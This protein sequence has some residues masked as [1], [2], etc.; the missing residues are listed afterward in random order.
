MKNLSI[1]IS[2]SG[3]VSDEL[4]AKIEEVKAGLNEEAPS[5]YVSLGLTDAP[6]P[7]P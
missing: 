1:S 3:L 4:A 7:Q 2:G 6:D 5:V